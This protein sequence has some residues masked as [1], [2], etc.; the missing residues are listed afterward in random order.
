LCDYAGEPY[1]L[2]PELIDE[3]CCSYFVDASGS[4]HTTTLAR[5]Q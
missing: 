1:H 5:V 3:A 2:T 4:N